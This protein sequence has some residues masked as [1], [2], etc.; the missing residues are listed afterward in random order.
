MYYEFSFTLEI[1][2]FVL[3]GH[4]DYFGFGYKIIEKCSYIFKL[5]ILLCIKVID[6]LVL[7]RIYHVFCLF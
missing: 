4:C 3:V 5:F 7:Y 1:L 2:T 6:S